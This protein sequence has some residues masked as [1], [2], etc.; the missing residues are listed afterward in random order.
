[1][2]T[3]SS[4]RS[5]RLL[6]TFKTSQ[7]DDLRLVLILLICL[8]Y[9]DPFDKLVS[10]DQLSYL[11]NLY[12]RQYKLIDD[13]ARIRHDFP[14]QK[15]LLPRPRTTWDNILEDA[16]FASHIMQEVKSSFYEEKKA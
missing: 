3:K 11:P 13:L 8:Y 1:M 4:K 16:K 9:T 6:F 5:V 7:R 15:L 12:L 10:N 2:P 14:E